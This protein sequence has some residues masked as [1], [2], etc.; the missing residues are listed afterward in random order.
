MT[1]GQKIVQTG[2]HSSNEQEVKALIKRVDDFNINNIGNP[3]AL[4]VIPFN[5]GDVDVPE[6]HYKFRLMF[7]KREIQRAFWAT[8]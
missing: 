6:P 5:E 4:D 3:V 1:T 7:P 8:G 2:L